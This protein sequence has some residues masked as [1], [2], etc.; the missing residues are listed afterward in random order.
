MS[1]KKKKVKNNKV[2]EPCKAIPKCPQWCGTCPVDNP[3]SLKKVPSNCIA[4][5]KCKEWCGLC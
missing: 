5:P 1:N 2:Y 4:K 3:K